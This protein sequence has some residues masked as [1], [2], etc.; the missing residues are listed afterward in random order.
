V[1]RVCVTRDARGQIT[2][3]RI[4]GHSGYAERGADIVCSAVSALAQAAA[5]GVERV[6]GQPVRVVQE[7]GRLDIE[8][9]SPFDAAR[10][11]KAQAILETALLG[12]MKIS[13]QYS[14]HV[15]VMVSGGGDRAC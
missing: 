13:E 6:A 5:L 8:L 11:E 10:W 3:L 15:T 2:R 14:A 4:R 1:V 12:I 9:E 7:T